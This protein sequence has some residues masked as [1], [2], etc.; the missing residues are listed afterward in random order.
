MMKRQIS[1]VVL[2]LISGLAVGQT[3]LP[4]FTRDDDTDP[5]IELMY[6]NE[7]N[8]VTQY[9]NENF[10]SAFEL[11]SGSA[12]QG[13]KKSQYMLAFMF[14]KGEHVNK[15]ILLGMGWLGVAKESG[16]KDWVELYDN[17]YARANP[18]Q[19][20]MIDEKVRQYVELYGMDATNVTCKRAQ[21][22]GSRRYEMRCIKVGGV[23]TDPVPVE[24]QP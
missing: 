22:A 14:L 6:R 11:F 19:Q 23:N 16:E 13:L 10:E 18:T 2:V 12:V 5:R 15:S 20:A 17:M 1:T 7:D 21:V 9:K 8:G 24:L 3:T 4:D